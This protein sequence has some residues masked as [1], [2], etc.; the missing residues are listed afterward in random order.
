MGEALGLIS[1]T[2]LPKTIDQNKH[3]SKENIKLVSR[4]MD[5]CSMSPT[6]KEMQIKTTMIHHHSPVR[7]TNTKKMEDN[8]H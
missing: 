1:C 3:F 2:L 6:V 7:M 5:T 4:N 8:K